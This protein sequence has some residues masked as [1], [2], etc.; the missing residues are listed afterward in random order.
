MHNPEFHSNSKEPQRFSFT[1]LQHS[2]SYKLPQDFAYFTHIIAI[3]SEML[4]T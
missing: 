3:Y 4:N 1:W 2:C